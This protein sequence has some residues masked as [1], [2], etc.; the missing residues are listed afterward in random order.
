MICAFDV[1][2]KHLSYCILGKQNTVDDWGI[3]N[4][5]E[6]DKLCHSDG[7]L[8]CMNTIEWQHKTRNIFYCVSHYNSQIKNMLKLKN[9]V[10]M[11]IQQFPCCFENCTVQKCISYGNQYYCKKHVKEHHRHELTAWTHY[12]HNKCMKEPL[13]VIG[14]IMYNKLDSKPAFLNTNKIIIENQPSL[15]NPTMKSVSLMLFSYFILHHHNDVTFVAPSGKL[16]VFEE[17]TKS[18]LGKCN[19]AQK[20]KITKELGIK[21]CDELLNKFDY[22]STTY[23]NIKKKDDMCDAFLHAFVH[24]YGKLKPEEKFKNEIL[25]YF[26]KKYFTTDDKIIKLNI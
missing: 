16:K 14:N 18:V 6:C 8:E 9:V 23:Q 19:K 25:D 1:G 24:S 3:F 15:T 10:D 22:K 11:D 4:L 20:Y 12:Q 2:I 13:H 17:L 7:T 21:Y 26:N 5:S